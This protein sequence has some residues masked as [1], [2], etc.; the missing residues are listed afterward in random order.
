MINKR[1]YHANIIKFAFVLFILAVFSD[2]CA[3]V[4]SIIIY[5][6]NYMWLVFSAFK[7]VDVKLEYSSTC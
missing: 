3:S 6:I 2:D 4:T 7:R 1:C 5:V